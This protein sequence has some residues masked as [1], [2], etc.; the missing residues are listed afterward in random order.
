M[1]CKYLYIC[2][3]K[4]KKCRQWNKALYKKDNIY[5]ENNAYCSRIVKKIPCCNAYGMI[6]LISLHFVYYKY[7]SLTILKYI[8]LHSLLLYKPASYYNKCI[9][10]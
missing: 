4:H 10:K 6:S 7:G 3:K 2:D 9:L 5:A 1:S 8:L